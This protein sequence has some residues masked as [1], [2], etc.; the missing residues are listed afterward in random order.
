ME[1]YD[2]SSSGQLRYLQAACRRL[3]EKLEAGLRNP[4]LD[5]QTFSA[6]TRQY[7]RLLKRL[8]DAYD[9]QEEGREGERT[10]AR[11]G[12]RQLAGAWLKD[13]DYSIREAEEI[14]RLAG[15]P[16]GRGDRGFLFWFTFDQKTTVN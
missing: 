8:K 15:E 1:M 3:E 11:L 5:H 7:M 13:F 10:E 14:Y 2:S 4:F 6:W 9:Q 12:D 16:F